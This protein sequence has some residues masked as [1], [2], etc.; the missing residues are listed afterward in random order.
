VSDALLGIGSA[1]GRSMGLPGRTA[2]IP[3][4]VYGYITS[5]KKLKINV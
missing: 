2:F 3:H 4:K 5:I 1:R